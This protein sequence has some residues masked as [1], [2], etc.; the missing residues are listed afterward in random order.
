VTDLQ[1]AQQRIEL[2]RMDGRIGELEGKALTQLQQ[3]ELLEL[4]FDQL[5]ARL[6]LAAREL[7]GGLEG[8]S[9]AGMSRERTRSLR[10]LIEDLGG[11]APDGGYAVD[12]LDFD[13]HSF[14]RAMLLIRGEV[15]PESDAERAAL[16]RWKVKH[17]PLD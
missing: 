10:R 2:D 17:G 4:R 6:S 14:E 13:D 16:E 15:E 7:T 1:H 5:H 3:I 8:K 11:A 9:V 12:V